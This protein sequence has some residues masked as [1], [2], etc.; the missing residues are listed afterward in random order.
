MDL[1]AEIRALLLQIPKGSVT[2]SRD[3][4]RALGDEHLAEVIV[5]LIAPFPYAHRV[6]HI[7]GRVESQKRDILRKEGVRIRDGKTALRSHVFKDFSTSYPLA[8]LREEQLSLRDAVRTR[9]AVTRIETIGGMDVAYSGNRGYGAYVELDMRGHTLK[10]KTVKKDILFPYIPSYLAYR[11]LPVLNALIAN[12]HPSL[13]VI[14]GNGILHPRGF[15]LASHFGV[16]HGI[17][18]IGVA[19]KLLCGEVRGRHIY[20]G[21]A[22][23]GAVCTTRGKPLYISPGHNISLTS[24]YKVTHAM[25]TYRIP[26]PVRKA[27][28]LAT[29][30]KNADLKQR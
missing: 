21:T 1:N 23:V 13:V 10:E 14:D 3:I 12:E 17:A 25:C 11:E 16:V 7:D 9:D 8:A 5:P 15:G 30:A 20:M 24:A 28:L 27:H 26:E 18:S 6:V 19:K 29:R 4:A 2:S 22:R